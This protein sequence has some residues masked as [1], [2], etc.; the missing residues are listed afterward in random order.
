MHLGGCFIFLLSNT[1]ILP[2]IWSSKQCGNKHFQLLCP[3]KAIC[4]ISRSTDSF[5]RSRKVRVSFRCDVTGWCKRQCPRVPLNR[6][7]CLLRNLTHDIKCCLHDRCNWEEMPLFAITFCKMNTK[8]LQIAGE[9]LDGCLNIEEFAEAMRALAEY[10]GN[11]EEPI[12]RTSLEEITYVN[13]EIH[14]S[15]GFD[16]AVIT[17][18]QPTK[19]ES[20]LIRMIEQGPGFFD[21]EGIELYEL[22]SELSEILRTEGSLL[23]ISTDVVVIG[24]LRGRYSDLLRWFQLYGYPPKRRYLFLGGI[25][26]QECAESV[27][28]LAFLAAYKV[29]TPNHIYII[30]GATEFFPFQIRKRFPVKLSTV[31][32][33]FITRIC[34]E[35]PI[36]ATIGNT[37]FAVHSGIS[38][39]LKNLEVIKKIERPPLKWD[40]R[41]LYDLILGMPSTAVERFQKIKGGRGHF[42]G[43]K[44]IEEFIVRLQMKL[45][46]RTHTPCEKG[47]FMFAS[48]Q[49][50]SIWSSNCNNVKLATSLYID[51]QLRVTVHCMTPVIVKSIAAGQIPAMVPEVEIVEVE[52]R[53]KVDK[54]QNNQR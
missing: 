45:I 50:L 9:P 8:N 10:R 33:A 35:M 31:L 42:F 37:I 16:Y 40:Y 47:H 24:E 28:T 34:S 12:V 49:V 19:F 43:V 54:V 44:A 5:F 6:E 30:R 7:W 2:V 1:A 51:P 20:L 36:A 26:D 52:E 13:Y 39:Q 41:I 11:V 4:I 27:E 46:I 23:E 21:I 15:L 29:T 32:S 18:I 38:S 17:R 3:E 14:E 53:S 48:K 25:I 22:L